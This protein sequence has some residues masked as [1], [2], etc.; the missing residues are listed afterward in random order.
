MKKIFLYLFAATVM[1]LQSCDESGLT[2]PVVADEVFRGK[3]TVGDYVN[4][5]VGISVTESSDSTVLVFFDNVKFAKAMPVYIDITL[6]D[7]PCNNSNGVL[8]FYVENI[9]PYLN[10]EKEASPNYRFAIVSGTVVENELLLS[11]KMSDDLAPSRAG[12]E[13]SF[14]GIRGSVE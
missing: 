6:K 3:L 9:D 7:V 1:L 12:K 10:K 4:N 11:A 5:S 2:P 8:S 14:R 13:F